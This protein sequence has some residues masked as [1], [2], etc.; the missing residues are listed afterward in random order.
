[1]V[2]TKKRF[3]DV[4]MNLCTMGYLPLPVKPGTK[5]PAMP[6]WND[7][8]ISKEPVEEWT[9]NGYKEHSVGC[10]L[11]NEVI[12]V[13]VDIYHPAVAEK[14][15]SWM[16]KNLCDGHKIMYRVGQQPKFLVLFQSKDI[17]RKIASA[18]Y[19]H[20]EHKNQHHGVEILTDGQQ[21]LLY[22]QHESTGTE[23]TWFND[24]PENTPTWI[25]PELTTDDV[26]WLFDHFE[27]LAE[28]N[29]WQTKGG[30]E[31]KQLDDSFADIKTPSATYDDLKKAVF[32]LPQRF[33]DVRGEWVRI[34]AIIHFETSGSEQ[35][36]RLFDT[37]SQ[38]SPFYKDQKDTRARWNSFSLDKTGKNCATY[39]T[40]LKIINDENLPQIVENINLFK[41][42]FSFRHVSEL[43]K[44]VKPTE[45]LIE[46][47]L[48]ANALGVLNGDPGSY[49]SFLGV[50]WGASIA[51]GTQWNGHTV[52][53]GPVFILI[54]EGHAGYGK[55]IV[56]W[57][58]NTGIYVSDA[59]IY[60]STAPVQMLDSKSAQI[61]GDAINEL[62]EHHGT[63]A[64]VLFDTLARNFGP[65]DENSTADMTKFIATLDSIIGNDTTRLLIHHTGHDNK[66]RGRGSSALKGAA[67]AEY[68]ITRND[69]TA[70]LRCLKMKDAEEFSPV[71]FMPKVVTIGGTFEDPITSLYLEKL[72]EPVRVSV[73]LSP[74]M[75][76]ALSLLDLI[77]RKSGISCLSEWMNICRD[78]E[79]YTKAAFYNAAKTMEN[80]KIIAITGDYVKRY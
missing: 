35:G 19:I 23:Y 16:E 12:A 80:K 76:Q 62:R 42:K 2:D 24:T 71:S 29:G 27:E 79:V 33:C 51:T 43:V 8:E 46:G 75:R 58:K 65:G 7:I 53:Q 69:E 28:E 31:Q 57:S 9:T 45:W 47:V 26:Q 39:A 34:G 73:T 10:R 14:M 52:S 68:L 36:Y 20:D 13:D 50:D 1:M 44:G 11:N 59:P 17:K 61:A 64:L 72:D 40:L 30:V 49:K 67:D 18:K 22:G 37:W 66:K 4:A 3:A 74:Q 41:R 5:K 70:T 6:E 63:P 55:R 77:T 25:L 60:I 56:A 54:G 78:E 32:S 38:L 21:C 15:R 48:E